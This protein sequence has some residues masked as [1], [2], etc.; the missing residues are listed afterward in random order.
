MGSISYLKTPGRTTDQELRAYLAEYL[1]AGHRVVAQATR[2]V[3]GSRERSR[4]LFAAVEDNAGAVSCHVLLGASEQGHIVI[5][6]LHEEMGPGG[7]PDP[8]ARVVT[9][10]TPTAHEYAREFRAE[11]A[12]ALERKKAAKA[13]VGQHVRFELPFL[14][15][16]ADASRTDFRVESLRRFTRPDGTGGYRA[17][18]G[19]WMRTFHVIPAAPGTGEAA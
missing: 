19:W 12:V 8:P 3:Y 15:R 2:S 16:G 13:V 14:Y 1:H 5:K 17:P 10:L 6:A 11:L 9:A 18:N 7:H 4:Q